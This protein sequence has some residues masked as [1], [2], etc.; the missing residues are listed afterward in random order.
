LKQRPGTV[1]R[2][3]DVCLALVELEQADT[4]V[5]RRHHV[6]MHMRRRSRGH[7]HSKDINMQTLNVCLWIQEYITKA[8]NDKT[9]KVVVAALDILTQAARYAIHSFA[10]SLLSPYLARS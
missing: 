7:I 5:V 1:K 8:F 2:C 9:P 3:A 4:V 10:C 6:V